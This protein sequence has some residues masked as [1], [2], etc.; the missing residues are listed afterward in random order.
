[1]LEK[2]NNQHF[3]W[4]WQETDCSASTQASD[5][6]LKSL[7]SKLKEFCIS[8]NGDNFCICLKSCCLK[9]DNVISRKDSV[10]VSS[11]DFILCLLSL[12][13]G[14][15]LEIEG[16]IGKRFK[17]LALRMYF[18]RGNSSVNWWELT[19]WGH[20]YFYG[21]YDDINHH[22]QTFFLRSSC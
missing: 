20:W 9:L 8:L 17:T 16:T 3:A 14:V 19:V 22:I 6:V 18:I 1:M 5:A 13:W 2:N 12:K 21:Y 7:T 10:I 15:L 4:F 11:C